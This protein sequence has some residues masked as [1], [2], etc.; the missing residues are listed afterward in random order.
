MVQILN[1]HNFKIC[2]KERLVGEGSCKLWFELP[3]KGKCTSRL[4]IPVSKGGL[5]PS[6]TGKNDGIYRFDHSSALENFLYY[7]D[8]FHIGRVCDAYYKLM[9]RGNYYGGQ[10]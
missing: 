4:D 2:F 7:G 3:Y 5:M 8:Y 6:C 10:V 9:L 1:Y